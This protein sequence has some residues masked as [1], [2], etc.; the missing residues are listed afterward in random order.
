MPPLSTR[1]IPIHKTSIVVLGPR[2]P[3]MTK[4]GSVTCVPLLS[5][6][7]TTKTSKCGRPRSHSLAGIWPGK[8]NKK[9]LFVHHYEIETDCITQRITDKTLML[10]VIEV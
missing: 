5:A 4:R 7:G 6:G 3:R 1:E 10:V 9:I 2:P 8:K